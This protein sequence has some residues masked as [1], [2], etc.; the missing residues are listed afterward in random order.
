M[1]TESRLPLDEVVRAILATNDYPDVS[2]DDDKGSSGA[3][4]GGARHFQWTMRQWQD[5]CK[6]VETESASLS[7]VINFAY[8]DNG[9]LRGN[10]RQMEACYYFHDPDITT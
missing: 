9:R 10:E 6:R 3:G 8:S 2:V 4:R 7:C 5:F 1:Q